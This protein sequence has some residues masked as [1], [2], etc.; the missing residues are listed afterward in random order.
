MAKPPTPPN[1]DLINVIILACD[2]NEPPRWTKQLQLELNR[3][4]CFDILGEFTQT[5]LRNDPTYVVKSPLQHG[6]TYSFG[7][8]VD[9]KM[10]MTDRSVA[11]GD[12]VVLKFDSTDV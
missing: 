11:D 12:E 5:E 7:G 4:R 9:G 2:G 3:T 10:Q 1:P 6:I 8:L